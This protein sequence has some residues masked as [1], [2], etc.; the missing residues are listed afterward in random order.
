MRRINVSFSRAR[1]DSRLRRQARQAGM[2][3]VTIKI[4]TSFFNHFS[5]KYA[6]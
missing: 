3:F 1:S 2:E 5:V 6:Y 4:V